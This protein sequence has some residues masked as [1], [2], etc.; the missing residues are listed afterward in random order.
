MSNSQSS[1]NTPVVAP[2]PGVDHNWEKKIAIAKAARDHGKALRAGKPP[3]FRSAVV[4]S[5]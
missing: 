3:S 1:K 2:P 5:R 4:R